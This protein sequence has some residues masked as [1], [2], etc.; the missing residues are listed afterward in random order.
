MELNYAFPC[1]QRR[2]QCRPL[3]SPGGEGCT[4]A[5]AAM[6][7]EATMEK[8]RAA[9]SPALGGKNR[10]LNWREIVT[11]AGSNF[12]LLVNWY[13]HPTVARLI[14][15]VK[16]LFPRVCMV[17]NASST[18]ETSTTGW[19]CSSLGFPLGWITKNVCREGGIWTGGV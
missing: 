2:L 12:A 8:T 15:D 1:L 18:H 7:Y 10:Q 19:T 17:W 4:R 11:G 6:P 9:A 3:M 13:S 14:S 5:S 16:I